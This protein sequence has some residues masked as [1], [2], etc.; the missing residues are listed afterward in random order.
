[1][2]NI[3]TTNIT[4]LI[5][6]FGQL[7]QELKNVGFEIVSHAPQ[8]PYFTSSFGNIYTQLIQQYPSFIDF[9]NIQ[10]YNNGPSQAFQEIFIQSD[11]SQPMTSILELHQNKNIP[12]S[13]LVMGKPSEPSCIL[14]FLN[15]NNRRKQCAHEIFIFFYC[16][17]LVHSD[18]GRDVYDPCNTIGEKECEILSPVC[19]NVC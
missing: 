19:R 14:F 7:S 5:Q 18:K 3:G 10:Y 4:E 9:L 13:K 17:D 6:S 15:T 12:L 16:V 11:S 8:H 2:E 1:M